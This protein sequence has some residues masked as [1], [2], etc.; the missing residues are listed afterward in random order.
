MGRALWSLGV[1][2]P[3]SACKGHVVQK[4]G[5]VH[6]EGSWTGGHG[7]RACSP[8]LCLKDKDSLCLKRAHQRCVH[9]C[10][11]GRVGEVESSPVWCAPSLYWA[12][13]GL[14]VVSYPE[15][16]NSSCHF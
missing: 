7:S 3:Y 15:H 1:V 10:V 6:S 2:S 12:E 4:E 11:S 16:M 13:P 14:R 5:A 9:P 8:R